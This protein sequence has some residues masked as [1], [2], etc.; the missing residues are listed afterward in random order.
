MLIAKHFFARLRA[1]LILAPSL[2]LFSFVFAFPFVLA[3]N[4][5]GIKIK[6]KKYKTFSLGNNCNFPFCISLCCNKICKDIV[7]LYS[8]NKMICLSI[9][10]FIS[11]ITYCK[12]LNY[13]NLHQFIYIIIVL[14]S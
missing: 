8:I 4:N 13:S 12:D 10:E 2:Y 7:L 9:Q 11:C 14:V 3:G 5:Y 1:K 6:K